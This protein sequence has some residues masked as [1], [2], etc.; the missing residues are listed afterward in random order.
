M[1]VGPK[2]CV[3]KR[4][5]RLTPTFPPQGDSRAVDEAAQLTAGD[6]SALART[7]SVHTPAN[8]VR[9]C[10]LSEPASARQD[11]RSPLQLEDDLQSKLD[12][13]RGGGCSGQESGNASWRPSWI[14]DVRI[15]GCDRGCEVRMIKDVEH[16]RTELN[17]EGLGNFTDVVVFEYREVNFSQTR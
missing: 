8:V 10:Q 7:T 5:P 11:P 16:F 1:P 17:V 13:S 6:F 4:V 14:K 15:V 3:K 9:C 12:F 2:L